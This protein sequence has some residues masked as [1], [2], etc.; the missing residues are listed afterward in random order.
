LRDNFTQRYI[1]PQN[2]SKQSPNFFYWCENISLMMGLLRFVDGLLYR[3][4]GHPKFLSSI[5]PALWLS[6]WGNSW[7]AFGSAMPLENVFL[8]PTWRRA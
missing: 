7:M 8:T 2:I 5:K 4:E 6:V 1:N 3:Q